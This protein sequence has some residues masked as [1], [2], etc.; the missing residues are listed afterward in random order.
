MAYERVREAEFAAAWA[1]GA[2]R[3][4]VVRAASGAAYVIIYEGRRGGGA[5]PDFRDAVLLRNDG[6][7]LYGDIELHLRP[8]G[9]HAHGHASDPRYDGLAL[10]VVLAPARSRAEEAI[11]TPLASGRRAP[12]VVLGSLAPPRPVPSNPWPCVACDR[13]ALLARLAEAGWT[14]FERRVCAAHAHLTVAASSGA[15][16]PWRAEDRALWPELAEALAYGRDRAALRACGDHLAA[17]ESLDTLQSA[18]DGLPRVE[19]DR[20]RG[21]LAL[22]ARWE[23][24]GPVATLAAILYPPCLPADALASRKGALPLAEL[25]RRLARALIV[26]GGAVSPGRATIV[27]ANVVL[28]FL[29]AWG[30]ASGSLRLAER[31]RAVYAALPGLPANTLTR[32]MSRQLGLRQQPRGALAQQGLHE[33][34]SATCRE[35]RCAA[36]ALASARG[37]PPRTGYADTHTL[38]GSVC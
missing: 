15:G 34:W 4:Q 17:G 13:S 29:A 35:K 12:L 11:E 5:G 33:V 19:R 18:G 38:V 21:L 26:S 22:A 23:E 3:G 2:W 31:A 8:A 9:W 6:V 14:R 37:S 27:V 32:T 30:H 36:C 16:G 28:P 7:R 10:H 20:L 24:R 1:A 25:G